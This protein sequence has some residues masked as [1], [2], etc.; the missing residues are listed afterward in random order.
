MIV[1]IYLKAKVVK[2]DGTDSCTDRVIHLTLIYLS[3]M[4]IELRGGRCSF[5]SIGRV[6]EC[7]RLLDP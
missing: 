1:L 6:E 3:Q 4:F 7:C 2:R 5:Q